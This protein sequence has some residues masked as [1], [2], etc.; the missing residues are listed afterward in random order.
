MAG[1]GIT[2]GCTAGGATYCPTDP[3]TREQMASFLVRAL[4][5]PPAGRDFF[6][7]DA[8]SIH[9]ADI[10]A[11]AKAGVTKGCGTGGYCPTHPVTRGQMAAF[12][13]RALAD[14]G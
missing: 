4:D 1:E 11:L 13:Y 12:L 14:Q 5:L 6:S 8:G 2:K 3:V 9:Q 7:D 10:N